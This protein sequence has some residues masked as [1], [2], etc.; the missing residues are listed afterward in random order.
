MGTL[1]RLRD[2]R[3]FP[4]P[5][6]GILGRGSGALIPLEESLASGEHARISWTGSAWELRDLGSKNGTFINGAPLQSGGSRVVFEGDRFGFGDAG[7]RYVLEDARAAGPM[8]I[9]LASGVW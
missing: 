8:A 6:R 9:E 7:E 4:L 5:S 3:R 1:L 2:Q